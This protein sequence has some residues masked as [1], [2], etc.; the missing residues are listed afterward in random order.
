MSELNLLETTDA[1]VWAKE[2]ERCKK[3]NNWTL[4]DIDE[5]L[6]ICW[7]ANAFTAQEFKRVEE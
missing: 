1:V 3:T 5:G 7:F 2:F 4:E 6:M